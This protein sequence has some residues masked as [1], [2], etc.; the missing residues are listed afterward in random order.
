MTKDEQTFQRWFLNHHWVQKYGYPFDAWVAERI[1]R[2]ASSRQVEAELIDM[3]G[4]A[5][6][7]TTLERWFPKLKGNTERVAQPRSARPAPQ[8]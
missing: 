2:G 7:H 3:I 5:P 1:E 6:A 8:P 4:R